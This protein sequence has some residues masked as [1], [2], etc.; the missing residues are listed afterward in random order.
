MKLEVT[1]ASGGREPPGGSG[2]G[3]DVREL[4]VRDAALELLN[5]PIHAPA[6]LGVTGAQV[7]PFA[8]TR[9]SHDQHRLRG[10]IEDHH[11]VVEAETEV[12]NAAVVRRG[13]GQAL[14]VPDRV[15]ARVADRAAAEPRQAR[16]AR[17]AELRDHVFEN[18]QRVGGFGF[19]PFP[20][21][22]AS[23][24]SSAASFKRAKRPRTE[25]AISP[26]PLPADDALEQERPVALLELA[27]RGDGRERVAGEPAV[28]RHDRVAVRQR[29]ELVE[30]RTV[31]H[32]TL[33]ATL[34]C[35]P[36][37]EPL[38]SLSG[39]LAEPER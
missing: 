4:H 27:E 23:A 20:V 6:R 31:R 14:D 21:P 29:G 32:R 26:D 34:S 36:K 38:L 9:M 35:C 3:V 25:E 18:A 8:H 28:H 11:A 10:L 5:Q 39:S 30:R 15:V 24:G 7:A 22:I 1:L 12:R 17:R 2:R 16:H 19:D 37:C 33:A 13:V